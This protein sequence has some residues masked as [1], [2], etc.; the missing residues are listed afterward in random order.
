MMKRSHLLSVTVAGGFLLLAGC[1]DDASRARAAEAEALQQAATEYSGTVLSNP[2]LHM[3]SHDDGATSKLSSLAGKGG[4]GTGGALLDASIQTDLALAALS[5]ADALAAQNRAA[6]AEVR[7]L[8]DAARILQQ[9]AA[10]H[11]S[12]L[13]D[14]EQRV[15]D[16]ARTQTQQQLETARAALNQISGPIAALEQQIQAN[17]QRIDGMRQ[18]SRAQREMAFDAGDLDGYPYIV[19]AVRIDS[20][21]DTLER[22]NADLELELGQLHAQRDM[23]Q[24][25]VEQGNQAMATFQTTAGELQQSAQYHRQE[26]QR[27]NS[28]A[29]NFQ[30]QAT[31]KLN[32]IRGV[33]T[34]GMND[35]FERAAQHAE[36]ASTRAGAA[37]PGSQ[38]GRM[39]K[40]RALQ[41]RARAYS[42]KMR[43]TADHA[44]LLKL[45]GQSTGDLVTSFNTA[46]E[47]TRNAYTQAMELLSQGG[48]DQSNA[49]MMNQLRTN[50]QQGINS[51][52]QD[53]EEVLSGAAVPDVTMPTP[54]SNSGSGSSA[55]TG[56][57][58]DMGDG[59]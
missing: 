36:Q 49:A 4:T 41:T 16:A 47:Q 3:A 37:G 29:A 34:G 19:E 25:L 58:A 2:D 46:A 27:L 31:A 26:A 53:L 20:D 33:M 55:P 52:S 38:A 7:G 13:N 42:S 10:R 39:M 54:P 17:R 14:S 22:R 18:E 44:M 12:A 45:A 30:Q 24:S 40:V 1:Q 21:A 8:L 23:V 57:G 50:L 9:Q 5:E 48:G 28:E 43:D 15:L 32:E 11:T 35:L 59:K 6:R 56:G 51:A